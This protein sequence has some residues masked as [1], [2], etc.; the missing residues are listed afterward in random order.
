MSD[1]NAT[2]VGFLGGLLLGATAGFIAGVL[3]APASGEETRRRW[4]RRIE[5]EAE[6]LRR[7]GRRLVE[8]AT[9]RIEDGIEEGRKGVQKAIRRS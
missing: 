6:D 9:E 3:I 4:R 7:K 8:D 1:T 2:A 5:D